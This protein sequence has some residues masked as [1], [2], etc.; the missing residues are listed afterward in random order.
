ME[1]VCVYGN[2]IK[3]FLVALIAPNKKNLQILAQ[4]LSKEK[5][6]L[7]NLCDDKDIR[8]KVLESLQKTLKQS[9][10]LK[11]EIPR[12]VKLC[13]DEWTPENGLVTAALKL[14]RKNLLDFYQK[15]INSMY[16]TAVLS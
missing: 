16:G 9:K 15:D 14:R 2:P 4:S 12:D 11:H 13:A 10:L 3:D 6:D 1:N 7:K 5:T 8:G